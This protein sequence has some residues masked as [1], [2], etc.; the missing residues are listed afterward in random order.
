[1]PMA[2]SAADDRILPETR[3]V[4]KLVVPFLL[5]AF[6]VLYLLP[7]RTEEL[8]AWTIEPQM[9]PLVMGAGYVA[10]AFLLG[11]AARATRWHEVSIAFIAASVFVWVLATAT[12]LGWARFNHD[13]PAFFIWAAL[14]AITPF[15]LPALWIRNRATDPGTLG[16]DDVELPG[17]LRWTLALAGIAVLVLIALTV[18]APE[19]AI[20]VWPW[21]LTPLTARVVSSFFAFL[22]VAWLV[23]GLDGRWS[24]GRIPVQSVILGT[25]LIAIGAVRARSD[26]DGS[27]S[28]W[29]YLLSLLLVLVTQ[30]VMYL[31]MERR[32]GSSTSH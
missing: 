15:L 2:H 13:H 11:R 23:L 10:G 5:V 6:V 28:T 25:G 9:T 8:F 4:A 14:Y 3:F 32:A 20:E 7:S 22:G 29:T 12:V 21:S 19:I 26:F 30:T 31:S 24:S 18:V 17:P 1:M 27:I 16:E